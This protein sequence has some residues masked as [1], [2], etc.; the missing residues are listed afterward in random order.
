LLWNWLSNLQFGGPW[1]YKLHK[2]PNFFAA[3]FVGVFA[4]F[5][6]S[7][8][9]N[10]W[11]LRNGIEMCSRPVGEHDRLTLVRRFFGQ[12]K[13]ETEKIRCSR[14]LWYRK[15]MIKKCV[16]PNCGLRRPDVSVVDRLL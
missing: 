5:L 15:K 16:L 14:A 4:R 7:S 8:S 12:T 1:E 2:R 6:C 13:F 9:K 3:L 10:A 11:T